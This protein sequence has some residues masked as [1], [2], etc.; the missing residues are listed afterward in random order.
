VKEDR[1]NQE[2]GL[3]LVT[4]WF[5]VLLL[6]SSAPHRVHHVFE[7]LHFPPKSSADAATRSEAHAHLDENSEHD[8]A[9]HEH[10]HSS[11]GSAKADCIAQALAQNS[12][13]APAQAIEVSYLKHESETQPA[14]TLAPHYHFRPSPFSQRAPPKA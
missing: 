10:D 12:H 9:S 4:V 13:L 11:G 8:N 7:D 6:V 2:P 5:F 14:V 3:A 1:R